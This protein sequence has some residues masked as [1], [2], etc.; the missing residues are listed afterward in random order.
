VHVKAADALLRRLARDRDSFVLAQV[1]R[2]A[3]GEDDLEMA[4][5]F[6]H[7]GGVLPDDRTVSTPD[8]SPL[9]KSLHELPSLQ[10]PA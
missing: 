8:S 5:G 7:V 10:E 4:R 9:C 1:L 2:A 6:G 3:F